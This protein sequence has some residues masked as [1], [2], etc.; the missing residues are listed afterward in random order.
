MISKQTAL[1]A[2]GVT[3]MNKSEFPPENRKEE[4]KIDI[5][6]AVPKDASAISNIQKEA[7]LAT[8]PNE[9]YGITREGIE[10]EDWTNERKEKWLRR[11]ANKIDGI[12]VAKEGSMAVGFCSAHW[13][14]KANVVSAIY[15]L[16][17]YQKYGVGKKLMEEAIK[18]LGSEKD[19]SLVV[20][21]YTGAIEF[22]KKLGF[23]EGGESPSRLLPG[24]M[25]PVIE[26][27]K[28]ASL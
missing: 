8:Y 19:I 11:I 25:V 6:E 22:Y 1:L 10:A 20:V 2:S 21:K 24:K 16:P 23:K 5:L 27:V 28:P 12:W 3:D 18:Y 14:E 9:E 17:Q 13:G 15:I 4:I 26:M 7:W